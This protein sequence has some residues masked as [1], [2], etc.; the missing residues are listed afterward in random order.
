MYCEPLWDRVTDLMKRRYISNHFIHSYVHKKL[1]FHWICHWSDERRCISNHFI[2]SFSLQ[3]LLAIQQPLAAFK[4]CLL[5]QP[6][7]AFMLCLLAL[8]VIRICWIYSSPWLP[9]NST[10]YTAAFGCLQ[11]RQ[12]SSFA[13]YTA[14]FG[15]LQA[16]LVIQQP[17]TAYT[18][19]FGCLQA[20]FCC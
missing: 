16:L 17:S 4:Y 10:C 3:A 1:Q 20:C 19:A 13:F 9:F 14:A 15:C 11:V 2:H 6:L 8:R 12:S 5:Q 7:A 18:A